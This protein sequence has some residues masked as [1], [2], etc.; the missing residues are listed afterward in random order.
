LR[1]I[2]EGE[3][4][5]RETPLAVPLELDTFAVPQD[6]PFVA[7]VM[8]TSAICPRG[9]TLC[10]DPRASASAVPLPFRPLTEN[11]D[12]TGERARERVRE[13][14]RERERVCVRETVCVCIVREGERERKERERER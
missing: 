12:S 8:T 3:E 9:G 7:S 2:T 4:G 10:T 14:E 13:I 1:V 5:L 6:A 11:C